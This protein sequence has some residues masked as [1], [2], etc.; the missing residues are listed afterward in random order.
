MARRIGRRAALGAIGGVGFGALLA[1]CGGGGS[2]RSASGR[3]TSSAPGSTTTSAGGAPSTDP[4]LASL[5]DDSASCAVTPEQT[6][7]PFYVDT[8]RIRRDIT[9]DRQGTPLRLALRVRDLGECTPIP[10]ALVDIWHSDAAG[11]YSGFEDGAGESFLRGVQVTDAD[12][13]V[14][15]ATIYPGAYQGRTVH[16]HA[17]VHLDN[18]TALTTQLYFDDGISDDVLERA[19]YRG[20]D[21]RTRNADDGLFVEQTVLTMQPEGEGYLG[22]MTFDVRS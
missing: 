10:D 16:I 18:R 4:S 1:A 8:D 2:E 11:V 9:E 3:T 22:I 12:G 6:E 14:Q 17:K 21:A 13:I 5:F 7:G 15:F 19:P 20:D